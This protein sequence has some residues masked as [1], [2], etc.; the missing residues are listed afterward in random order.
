MIIIGERL[1]T[2]RKA[3]LEA[4]KAKNEKYLQEDAKRQVESGASIIDVNAGLMLEEEPKYLEWMV[5]VIQDVVDVPLAIDSSNPDAIER[6]LKVHRGQALV[7]SISL[8]PECYNSL[9]H[10]LVE[11]NCF[12]VSLCLDERGIPESVNDRLEVATKLTNRLIED[13]VEAE[14]VFLD[15]LVTSL[16][17]D[18]NAARIAV[19]TIDGIKR[20]LKG[21]R[22]ALGLSNISYGLPCRRLLNRTFLTMLM[23]VGLDAAIMD[24]TDRNMMG[25]LLATDAL[26]GQDEFCMRFIEATRSGKIDKE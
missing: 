14:N 2:S 21:C 25:T 24:P 10:L 17:T 9:V 23:A 20:S 5:N 12:V 6:A 16:A 19:E 4:V 22:T 26:V 1:N 15:P 3:V 8:E 13:K 7:N 11:H 18:P